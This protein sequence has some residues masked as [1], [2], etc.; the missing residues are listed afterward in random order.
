MPPVSRPV[1]P[2]HT[3]C[4]CRISGNP[5]RTSGTFWVSPGETPAGVPRTAAGPP[6]EI[7]E[8]PPGSE[9]ANPSRPDG[10]T[11]QRGSRVSFLQTFCQWLK[12]FRAAPHRACGLGGPFGPRAVWGEGTALRPASLLPGEESHS[13]G[14]LV[15]PAPT[16]RLAGRRPRVDGFASHLRPHS[17][18]FLGRAWA[19]PSPPHRCLPRSA[20]GRGRIRKSLAVPSGPCLFLLPSVSSGIRT[21][22]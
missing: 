13:S 8:T 12:V 20:L 18:L 14:D 11:G 3:L 4:P 1:G 9:E 5:C 2:Y 21:Q 6:A 15:P 19:G 7:A 16:L 22:G 17:G 10:P